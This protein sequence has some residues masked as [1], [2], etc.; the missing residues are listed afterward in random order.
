MKNEI[1]KHR[2]ISPKLGVFCRH[3]DIRSFRD[4]VLVAKT[5][6]KVTKT[7]NKHKVRLN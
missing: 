6:H 7:L 5:G 3:A 1:A 4:S 2:L